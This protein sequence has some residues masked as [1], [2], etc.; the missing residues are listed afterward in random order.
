MYSLNNAKASRGVNIIKQPNRKTLL[1]NYYNIGC[2]FEIGHHR[3]LENHKSNRQL[4]KWKTFTYSS[5][6]FK[7]RFKN[8]NFR[9]M[10]F[11]TAIFFY[12]IMEIRTFLGLIL[13]LKIRLFL[14][15]FFEN[16][17]MKSLPLGTQNVKE[18]PLPFMW[19]WLKKSLD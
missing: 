18:S 2:L 1:L 4:S 19:F 16:L 3:Y 6:T 5:Q 9:S 10:F 17:T 13:H 12:I 14:V 8:F 15:F 11:N 7:I